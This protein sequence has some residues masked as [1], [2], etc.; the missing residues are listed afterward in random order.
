[1]L[2]VQSV[3]PD[4]KLRRYVR[5]YAQRITS[6]HGPPISE[7]V[8]AR[9]EP[10]LE[11]ELGDLFEVTFLDGT[12]LTTPLCS[13]VGPQSR[14]RASVLLNGNVESFAI[15]FQPAGFTQLF[16]VPLRDLIDNAYCADSVI[17]VE[18][19]VLWH[20]LKVCPSFL[21]RVAI[22]DEVLIRAASRIRR[23]AAMGEQVNY[24]LACNG[25][26]S[27]SALAAEMNVSRR[28]FER[29]FMREIGLPPKSFARIA[30]FQM[31][32]DAKLANPRRSWLS[33]AHEFRYHDQM[34]MIHDFSALANGS[35]NRVLA[36]LGDMRPDALT[37]SEPSG[38][39]QTVYEATYMNR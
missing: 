13:I 5:A 29:R 25:A 9:L 1:M 30:R 7:N 11:F 14:L 18:V 2:Q 12:R 16:G 23:T 19:R 31:A 17:G 34:H 15:F 3:Q 39:T 6:I 38:Q 22:V 27:I 10:T 26:V 35:P 28:Q 24:I 33:I 4:P 21:E 8:P 36:T 20:R 37:R 32:L